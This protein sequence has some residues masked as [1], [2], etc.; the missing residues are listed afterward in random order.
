MGHRGSLAKTIMDKE[1]LALLLLL[2][3]LAT[4]GKQPQQRLACQ[5]VLVE[6]VKEQL[7][8][9][10]LVL[11]ELLLAS[12]AAAVR[13]RRRRQRRTRRGPGPKRGRRKRRRRRREADRPGA[14]LPQAALARTRTEFLS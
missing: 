7:Q 10:P 3:L 8:E 13:R 5:V 2:E 14:L 12:M 4:R 9:Q 11:L 1:A 6:E